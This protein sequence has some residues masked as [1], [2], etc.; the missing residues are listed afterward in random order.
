MRYNKIEMFVEN[1][2]KHISKKQLTFFDS[3]TPYTYYTCL[4]FMT[5]M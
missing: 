1:K 3:F 4:N 2:V 5:L